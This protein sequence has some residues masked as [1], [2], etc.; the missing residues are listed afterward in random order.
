MIGTAGVSRRML[1]KKSIGNY[2]SGASA[3][4]LRPNNG[5]GPFTAGFQKFVARKIDPAFYEF[6]REAIPIMDTAIWR[7]VSLDGS[8][9][10]EGD[11]VALV[12]ELQDWFDNV[13]V[14]DMQT[15][16]QAFHQNFSN[17]AFEQG[18]SLSEFIPNR[19]R[20][21]IVGLRVADSKFI[22]FSR[23]KSGLEI[24][25]KS[26]DDTDY[27]PLNTET[28]MYWSIHNENQNPYGTPLFR[29][30]EFVAQILAT[31]HNSLLNVW[32][33][34]GDPSFSLI[35]K[36]S[37][38]DGTN[39]QERCNK[40]R[41]DLDTVVRAKRMGKSADFVH[42]IDK[43]SDIEIKV[44]G[45]E[46]EE[47]AL[48]VPA[49]HVLEQ[50]VS[51]TG[52]APWMLG[53]H[54]STTE[55]LAE[56]ESEMVLADIVTRQD[57]KQP[58]FTRLASTLL[59]MR[60]RTWKKGDWSV[61]FKQVNLH[62]IEKQARAR[63]LNAQADM[64]GDDEPSTQKSSPYVVKSFTPKKKQTCKELY[65]TDP[66]PEL[67]QV[68]NDYEDTLKANW[69]KLLERVYIIFGLNDPTESK[70]V[71]DGNFTFSD[72]ERA[73]ILS[74]LADMVGTYKPDDPDSPVTYY[75][76]QAYSLG[77]IQA[78]NLIGKDQP[79]LNTLKN[80]EIFD[81]L[82]ATGFD[83]VKNNATKRLKNKIL[84]EM[85]A[86]ALSGTNPVNV[87]ERLRKLFDDANSD[88]ERLA[89]SEMSMAAEK[90]KLEEWKA[91][92]IKE[93]HFSPAPDACP[94]CQSLEGDYP[95]D[96][97]PI[98]VRDTH[99]RCRCAL[100]PADSEA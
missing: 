79:Q 28:L 96:E 22:K 56:F 92:D 47:L 30:C 57:A 67:D 15:G 2:S 42:A 64:M 90:A 26:D 19:K 84:T 75:Y 36:T 85:E 74:A 54:W 73:L 14:N 81:E 93:V 46:G 29:S 98:P 5:Q 95:I 33:R 51:K 69:S 86:F 94:Q 11:N 100:R 88:W 61:K 87:A 31:M 66:W 83:L 40:L 18:F 24:L 7:L 4:Q 39:H 99:P 53:M 23:I 9:V 16:I 72:I 65:R 44:I 71:S 82:T 10:V 59:R 21:D 8:I 68:E 80:K 76:G 50:V 13:P 78:A 6:L 49:R 48:E 37:R 1:R 43:D 89:R 97:A 91:W 77:L 32:E 20:N 70:G 58:S 38:K 52:L 63:F 41:D 17:E 55:R 3:V 27:R 25:Q 12:D 45:S 35:Y 34:F 62:D 60:G